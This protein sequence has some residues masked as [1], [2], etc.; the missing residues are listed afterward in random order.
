MNKRRS[1]GFKRFRRDGLR[2]ATGERVRLDVELV[3]GNVSETLLVTGKTPLLR[4]ETGSLGQVIGN[5]AIL[6]LPLNG[7]NFVPL[8]AL[9][10]G[11][12]LPP[13]SSFPGSTADGPG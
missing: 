4:A 9:S 10:S 13:G 6:D 5:R 3:I 12:A 2:L 11:V 7:R 1:S 8:V